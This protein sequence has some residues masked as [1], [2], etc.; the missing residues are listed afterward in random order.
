MFSLSFVHHIQDFLYEYQWKLQQLTVSSELIAE[1]RRRVLTT[2][3]EFMTPEDLH[4]TSH[5]S[6]GPDEPYEEE[7]FNKQHNSE[8][9][10]DERRVDDRPEDERREDKQHE[11]EQRDEQREDERETQRRTT[12]EQT[13]QGQHK[14][15]S[16]NSS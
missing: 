4:C 12:Q 7:E 1:A 13:K 3:T 9:R 10:E 16:S 2:A 14:R 15:N 5:V 11:D 8:Q 6:P